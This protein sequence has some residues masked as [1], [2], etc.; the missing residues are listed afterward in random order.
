MIGQLWL[1]HYCTRRPP[2]HP[3]LY[4]HPL[5]RPYHHQPLL[6]APCTLL[7]IQISFFFLSFFFLLTH[8]AIS[9]HWHFHSPCP[10]NPCG[11]Y[12]CTQTRNSLVLNRMSAQPLQPYQQQHNPTMMTTPQGCHNGGGDKVATLWWWHCSGGRCIS[13]RLHCFS[14]IV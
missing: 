8:H 9:Q 11:A 7:I 2:C 12:P 10:C 13:H 6:Q 4:L 14:T 3:I 5:A 1:C